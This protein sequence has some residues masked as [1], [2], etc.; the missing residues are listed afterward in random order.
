MAIPISYN[1]RNLADRKTTTI[2]TALGIALTVAVM[3]AVLALVEGLRTSLAATGNPLQVLVMRQGATSELVSLMTRNWFQILRSYPGVARNDLGEPMASLE[4]VTIVLLEAPD[5]P[6]GMNVTV[7]GLLPVGFQMREEIEIV[8]GRMFQTGRREM[9]VG[10]SVAA[11][12]PAAGLGGNID[13]G[14]GNWEV[15]GIMDAGQSSANGEIFCDLN[16]IAADQNRSDT[17][18]SA[19]LRASD[20]AGVQALIN[21]IDNDR[22]MNVSAITEREYYEQQ[23]SS[24]EPIRIMGLFIAVIMAIGSCFA[25][26]NTMYAAVARRTSEIG[27]LR[28]L[29]FSRASILASFTIEA[30]ILS[31]LGGLLGLLL[32]LPLTGLTAGIGSFQTFSEISFSFRITPTIAAVGIVFALLMGLMGGLFPA[33]GAARKEILDALR[34]V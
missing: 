14:G 10:K 19:L 32:V 21:E 28:V 4:M 34:Q 7:R 2:M 5:A 24:A 16:Q 29:G 9:V 6:G 15:V 18:S 25:A 22:R 11:R 20:A 1:L 31:L 3:M 13:F 27:T 23:T 12:Y 30:L 26:M 33:G 8:E 17:L